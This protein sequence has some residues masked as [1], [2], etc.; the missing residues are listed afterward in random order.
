MLSYY[1][2][3]I[4]IDIQSHSQLYKLIRDMEVGE[5]YYF[6]SSTRSVANLIVTA[7]HAIARCERPEYN[8]KIRTYVFQNKFVDPF[9]MFYISRLQ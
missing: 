5:A 6:H 3:I 2:E 8:C 1:K 7:K 9:K 4:M